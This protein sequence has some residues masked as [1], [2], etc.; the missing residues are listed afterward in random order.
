MTLSFSGIMIET[1]VELYS[2]VNLQLGRDPAGNAEF[3]LFD[4]T[5][6]I[7]ISLADYINW[8]LAERDADAFDVVIVYHDLGIPNQNSLILE[9]WTNFR[10]TTCITDHNPF[11][12]ESAAPATTAG[13]ARQNN[14]VKLEGSIAHLSYEYQELIQ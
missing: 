3:D 8:S 2:I 14:L 11:D 9:I 6:F 13:G 10:I 4:M 7:T 12:M 5:G 1:F